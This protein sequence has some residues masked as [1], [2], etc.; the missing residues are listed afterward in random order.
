VEGRTRGVH[1]LGPL[2]LTATDPFGLARRTYRV[3]GRTPV[4]VAPAIVDLSPLPPRSGDAG[5]MRQTATAQ[6]GQ[7][8]DD[9]VARPYAPGDS[10]RRIH[11]RATAHRDALMVRQEE[12][13]ASPEAAVVLDRG[14]LRWGTEALLTPGADPAFETAV[15]TAVSAVMRLVRDGYTVEVLDSDGTLLSDPITGG[16]TSDVEALAAQFATLTTRR[17]DGLDRLSAV[18]SGTTSGPVILVTGR[19]AATDAPA[20]AGVA[21]HSALPVLL[22]VDAPLDAIDRLR[23]TGWHAAGLASDDDPEYAWDDA[24]RREVS[25]VG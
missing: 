24:V 16:E 17:G 12:Q 15:C 9:L 18:F 2:T 1:P 14:A 13:E 10:M 8:S 25:R 20:L 4:T 11:W 6:L 21:H 5:G 19:I 23:A 22:A 7:G 3:G